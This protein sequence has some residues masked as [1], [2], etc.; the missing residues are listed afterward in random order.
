MCCYLQQVPLTL[1]LDNVC[2]LLFLKHSVI[3]SQIQL[4]LLPFGSYGHQAQSSQ[5]QGPLAHLTTNCCQMT[6]KEKEADK[7]LTSLLQPGFGYSGFFSYLVTTRT[8][9]TSRK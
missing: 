3:T 1:Q 9:Y 2:L 4:I 7:S 5:S 6:P 8:P